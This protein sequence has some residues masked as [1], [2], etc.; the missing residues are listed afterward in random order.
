MKT[1]GIITI[2]LL[3]SLALSTVA[4][5]KEKNFGFE[6]STGISQ[7]TSNP[8]ELNLQTGFGFEGIFHYRFLP[9]AGIY[10][11]WGWNRFGS[12]ESFAGNDVCFEETGYVMGL[13]FKHPLENIPVSVFF[14]AGALYN[15]IEVENAAGDIIA[16]TGHGFGWQL[17]AGVDLKLGK[18]WSLTPGLKFN[19][20][21]GDV[22]L[23]NE[24][25]TINQNYLSLRVGLLKRF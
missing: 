22:E 20:L 23:D 19:H 15:H 21:S 5:E 24:I 9:H 2:L 25:T 6:F 12:E 11:G 13:Q 7:A 17:A 18:N 8:D 16:D 1:K 14:R 3:T 10:G 4:Q